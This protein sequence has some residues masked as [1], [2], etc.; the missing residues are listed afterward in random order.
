LHHTCTPQ[1]HEQAALEREVA[2]FLR[3]ATAA[4]PDVTASTSLAGPGE[5]LAGCVLVKL[6]SWAAPPAARQAADDDGAAAQAAA[7]RQVRQRQ[8]W[9]DM[10]AVAALLLTAAGSSSAGGDA[11]PLP[12]LAVVHMLGSL[13]TQL[14]LCR[15]KTTTKLLRRSAKVLQ[16]LVRLGYTHTDLL[17]ALL[18]A[19][20][21]AGGA[22]GP[23]LL[24]QLSPTDAA[25]LL[26]RLQLLLVDSAE[27]PVNARGVAQEA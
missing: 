14:A 20:A 6:Q 26:A 21:D 22:H 15:R 27:D 24:Q 17:D 19:A 8:A 1:P 7:R 23:Q 10:V 11:R 25:K 3:S 2:A 16:M 5:R 12:R 4:T 18:A 9:Q 13:S